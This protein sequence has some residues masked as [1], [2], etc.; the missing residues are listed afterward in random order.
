MK[1]G[2]YS[3]YSNTATVR[4]LFAVSNPYL[5]AV[6]DGIAI[7]WTQSSKVSEHVQIERAPLGSDVWSQVGTASAD[8]VAAGWFVDRSVTELQ[9]YSYRLTNWAGTVSSGS[10]NPTFFLEAP[11]LGP[12]QV[13]AHPATNAMGLSWTNIS[14]IATQVQV[15]RKPIYAPFEATGDLLATLPASQTTYEDA[16]LASGTYI[17]ILKHTD[18][19]HTSGNGGVLASTLN[20]VGSP[21]LNGTYTNLQLNFEYQAK[22]ALAPNGQWAFADMEQARYMLYVEPAPW[23][24]WP[25]WTSTPQVGLFPPQGTYVALGTVLSMDSQSRPHILYEDG[26]TSHAQNGLLHTW[27][28]GV[29]WQTETVSPVST[30]KSYCFAMDRADR[31]CALRSDLIYYTKATGAWTIESLDPSNTYGSA[32]SALSGLALDTANAPHALLVDLA[33]NVVEFSRR[34]E[35]GWDH[36]ILSFQLPTSSSWLSDALWADASNATLLYWKFT[37]GDSSSRELWAAQK[38][39]G[40]WQP[41]VRLKS[42]FASSDLLSQPASAVISPDGS[43]VAKVVVTLLGCHLFTL[44]DGIWVESVLPLMDQGGASSTINLGFDGAN[45][46]HVLVGTVD[47]HE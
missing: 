41:G 13:V 14:K 35:G 20:P 42:G 3:G 44:K 22:L 5:V 21:T 25:K 16:S 28:D 43:R 24:T 12:S 7:G 27:Y 11:I 36:S 9:S 6:S 37:Q 26:G 19:M 46:L 38:V 17:Y 39:A 10:S 29:S 40:S 4:V 32:Y 2:N 18:G 8:P 45:R 47:Y 30:M 1:G 31:P 23:G 15:Y 34:P 33:G